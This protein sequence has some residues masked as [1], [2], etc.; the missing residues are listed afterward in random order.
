MIV[1]EL[2]C[3]LLLHI[4]FYLLT[5]LALANFIVAVVVVAVA[6]A[7]VVAVIVYL[8]TSLAL[9]NFI[10]VVV[11]FAVAVLVCNLPFPT[12][13]YL[14]LALFDIFSKC[15]LLLSVHVVD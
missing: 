1:I 8:L 12:L 9:A 2:Q 14:C 4:T 6:V 15:L 3:V 10:V 13:C 7:V 5:S 11:A